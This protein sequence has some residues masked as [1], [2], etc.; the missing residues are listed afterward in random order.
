[1]TDGKRKGKA[2]A[3]SSK[4]KISQPSTEI[5]DETSSERQ[6]TAKEKADQAMPFFDLVKFAN[7]YCE[8]K[9]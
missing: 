6:L 8:L 5:A 2:K 7:L 1:M 4:R 9:F 3:T